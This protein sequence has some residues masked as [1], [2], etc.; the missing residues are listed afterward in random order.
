MNRR[1]FFKEMAGYTL[2]YASVGIAP[3]VFASDEE[4]VIR[5]EPIADQ[6]VHQ[7][8][9]RVYT[10][11]APLEEPTPENRGWFS[12][13]SFIVTQKGVVVFDTGS[14]VQIGEMILRSIRKVTNKPVVAVF[15]SHMHGD[16]VLG[17][18][19]FTEKNPAI[20]IY[21]TDFTKTMLRDGEG[22]FWVD[23]F[24]RLT[25]NGIAGTKVVLPAKTATDGQRFDMGDCTLVVHNKGHG[26]TKGDIMLEVVE[27][28]VVCAGDALMNGRIANMDGGSFAGTIQTMD[29][30][31][32]QKEGYTF[33]PGHGQYSKDLV[34]NYHKLYTLIHK[35][36]A[37]AYDEGLES[38][39]I[40]EEIL[41]DSALSPYRSWVG[42]QDDAA[43]L[44]KFLSLAMLEIEREDLG[45]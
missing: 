28:K 39:E 4:L 27:D 2:A 5:A 36:A 11:I 18:Q 6:K 31:T 33:I 41:Q 8:S 7:V 44:G 16:H 38:Y 45:G 34:E 40:K 37:H 24:G 42:I 20:P 1:L 14:S 32:Q 15:N 35:Y 10:Y 3:K 9:E 19:A 23:L 43:E 22:K 30:L 13:P 26:H 29:F 12:N 17:N 25:E 21:S